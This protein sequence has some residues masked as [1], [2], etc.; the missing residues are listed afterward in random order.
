MGLSPEEYKMT[1]HL[2][3][4]AFESGDQLRRCYYSLRQQMELDDFEVQFFI[5]RFQ[6]VQEKVVS[7]VPKE[8]Q[9]QSIY[10]EF[11]KADTTRSGKINYATFCSTLIKLKLPIT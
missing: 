11:E 2:D 3:P 1:T 7:L 5:A 4:R 9:Q 10:R 6:E 8:G